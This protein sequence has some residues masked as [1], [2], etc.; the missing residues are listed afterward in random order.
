[1]ICDLIPLP[2][3]SRYYHRRSQ[4]VNDREQELDSWGSE[5][6]A[7]GVP[8]MVGIHESMATGNWARALDCQR[9]ARSAF[10]ALGRIRDWASASHVL[11]HVLIEQG[12][13]TEALALC[14]E[15]TRHGQETGDRVTEA[16]GL[17]NAGEVHF[18]QGK[19]AEAEARLVPA[20]VELLVARDF[21]NA[22]MAQ[23]RLAHCRLKQGEL[24]E[25]R[26]LLAEGRRRIR[27]NG[28]RGFFARNVWT[29]HAAVSLATV[30]YADGP[31][32]F[33]ALE[34][35]NAACRMLLK[36]GKL[37]VGAL[38]PGYRMRGTFEWLR[39]NPRMAEDWWRKSVAL[40]DQ[41]GAR[42]EGALT[43][44]EIGRWLGVRA[45][46]ECAEA[47]FAD[48]GAAF[49]LAEAR[50]LLAASRP[51]KAEAGSAHGPPPAPDHP[52]GNA[53]RR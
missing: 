48:I 8:F 29:G 47:E 21:S 2:R 27:E 20:T 24:D 4:L 32:R 41:L 5:Y 40:A 42:W 10:F 11:I 50:R 36:H 33:S 25:A 43:R 22:A 15:V 30:E 14:S 52:A 19:F 26:V 37:D 16:W 13:L 35:A 9:R 12:K 31:Q 1:M 38:V 45:E 17:M 51:P 28:V 3:L 23:G 53:G 34:D 6:S 18:C 46:I 44:L 49:D 39:G 7:A